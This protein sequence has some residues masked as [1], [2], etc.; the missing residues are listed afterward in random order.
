VSD[1]ASPDAEVF[2]VEPIGGPVDAVVHLPGSKSLTNRA[3]VVAALA[4]GTSTLVGVLDADDT[5]AM[6]DCLR[7]LGAEV[8]HDRSA[9]T[10]VVHGVG[11]RPQRG[12]GDRPVV[13]AARLSGTTS[14]FMLA[15]GA[16]GGGPWTV[17]GLAPLRARPMADGIDALRQLGAAVD[18]E[19]GRLPATVSGGPVP[20]GAVTVAGATSSQFLSGLAMAGA[21]M[22]QGLEVTVPGPLVSEPYLRMT[23]AVMDAFGATSSWTPDDLGGGVLAVDRGGYRAQRFTVEPDASAASYF[24][25][26]A[27]VCGGTVRVPGIRQSSLQG[28]AGFA[29]VLEQ[30]GAT[31]VWGD[32]GVTVTGSGRLGGI[33]VDLGAM[34][35]TAP[36]LA[37]VAVFADGPT[38]V[39]GVG[40]IRHKETDRI[41]S[42]VTELGRLGVRAESTD[43]GFIVHP[44]P[45]HPASVHTYDDHRMAMAFA[46]IGLR[47]PGVAIADPTCVD[48]TFPGYFAE[49]DRLRRRA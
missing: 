3:L 11:G 2:E 41:G 34:S 28:D 1:S 17:D 27:V 32:E 26:A 31:V 42:V 35:D 19:Q 7:L 20:G 45:V 16:L 14:R 18:C 46:V 36:T 33:T 30:M 44:G 21:C 5:A 37:A 49:L 38:E 47:V 13:L 39:T 43:D 9:A 23:L 4:A 6:V 10:M 22:P 15:A 48:K 29:G 40:F 8:V 24:M 12:P 25:A